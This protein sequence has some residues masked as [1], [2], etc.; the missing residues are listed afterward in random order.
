MSCGQV[1]TVG[2]HSL[3]R[4]LVLVPLL[5]SALHLTISSATTALRIGVQAAETASHTHAHTRTHR[6]GLRQDNLLG[7][8]FKARESR[9]SCWSHAPCEASAG[10]LLAGEHPL[11]SGR[12]AKSRGLSVACCRSRPA[13]AP[14][15]RRWQLRSR[16]SVAG[17]ATVR[18]NNLPSSTATA[19]A[20]A[21]AG[22]SL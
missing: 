13:A 5:R 18:R 8:T 7:G 21:A 22:R 9:Q 6:N 16:S 15:Q 11:T 12:S 19:W 1:N 20:S 3:L 2:N 4:S 14:L 10:R 17:M